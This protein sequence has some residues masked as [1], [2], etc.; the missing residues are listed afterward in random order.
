M[1]NELKITYKLF[2]FDVDKDGIEEASKQRFCRITPFYI[3]VYCEAEKAPKNGIEI[4]QT[5]THRLSKQDEQ[6]LLDCNLVILAEEAKKHEAEITSTLQERIEQI[7]AILKAEK[8][9]KE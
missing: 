5:E 3:L 6:W 7:E 1:T 2:A 4:T 9:A 8:E